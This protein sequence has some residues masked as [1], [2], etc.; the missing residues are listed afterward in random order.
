MPY[1]VQSHCAACVAG[2]TFVIGH[3]TRHLGVHVCPR[4][5]S[6]VNVPVD[7]GQCPGCGEPVAAAD[8]YDYSY[9]IPYFSGQTPRPLEPG[10]ACPKCKGAPLGFETKVHINLGV[11]AFDVTRARGTWG[12]D[13]LEKSIFMNSSIPV[14]EEFQLDPVK[15]FEYINLHLPTGPIATRR[16][17]YPIVLDIRA[18]LWTL[19]L[20]EPHRFARTPAPQTPAPETPP[21]PLSPADDESIR[22]LR[23]RR[24]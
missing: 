1:Q 7:T 3:W 5:Q 24:G 18:H 9:A 4:A 6:I 21:R 8:L 14:I 20:R 22:R 23:R 17:S 16:M 11:V 2:E 19:L 13:Y 15:V 10:P 12:R